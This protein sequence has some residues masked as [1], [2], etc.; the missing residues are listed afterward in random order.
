MIVYMTKHLIIEINM[1]LNLIKGF[2]AGY[3]FAS[4]DKMMIDYKGKRY[5]VAFEEVC[6]VE[7]EEM[8]DTMKK[9]FM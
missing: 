5:I 1:I 6:N 9:H 7:D 4:D 3:S 2:V 8:I